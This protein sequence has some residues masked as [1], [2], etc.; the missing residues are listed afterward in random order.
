M[1]EKRR[2]LGMYMTENAHTQLLSSEKQRFLQ[3]EWPHI[4]ERIQRLGLSVNQ[5][6]ASTQGAQQ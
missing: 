6:I 5:L 1:V 4:V 3:D 2:G